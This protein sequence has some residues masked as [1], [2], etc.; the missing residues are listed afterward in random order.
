MLLLP[1]A[2][3]SQLRI[4]GGVVWKILDDF[5]TNSSLSI[6]LKSDRNLVDGIG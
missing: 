6:A 5:P 2:N 4:C 3:E 1:A